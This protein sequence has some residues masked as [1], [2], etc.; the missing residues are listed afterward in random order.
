MGRA[1][2]LMPVIPALWEAKT[3]G[4]RGQEIETILA[5]MRQVFTMLARLVSNS[6]TQVFCSLQPPKVLGLQCEP[7][8]PNLNVMLC[9]ALEL[10]RVPT[11]KKAVT[12]YGRLTLDFSAFITPGQQS[13]IPS[14]KRRNDNSQRLLQL[15]RHLRIDWTFSTDSNNKAILCAGYCPDSFVGR[16]GSLPTLW[17]AKASGSPELL[18]RL[19]QENLLNPG[20]EICSEPR[21]HHCTPAWVTRTKLSLKKI[22]QKFETSLTNMSKPHHYK[23]YKNQPDVVVGTCDLSYSGGGGGRVQSYSVTQAESSNAIMAHYSLNLSGSGNAPT[24]ASRVAGTT[25]WWLTSVILALWE[26]EVG[27]SPEVRSSRPAWPSW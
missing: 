13:E 4:S 10:C 25:A 9:S 19:R 3:G 23:K 5:N 11:S 2:W 15:P 18:G 21:S 7:L 26:A 27:G 14:P 17:E 22:S 6:G 1:R 12:R 8:H 24:S 20:G 16:S